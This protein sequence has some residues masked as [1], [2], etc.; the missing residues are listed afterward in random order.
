MYFANYLY[1]FVQLVFCDAMPFGTWA[2][3]T[4]ME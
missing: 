4:Y 2:A 3:C 1:N